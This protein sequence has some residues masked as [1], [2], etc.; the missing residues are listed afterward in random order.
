MVD[1]N[2]I[3]SV[4]PEVKSIDRLSYLKDDLFICALGFEP[5]CLSGVK[6]LDSNRYRTKKAIY[7]RYTA[8]DRENTKNLPDLKEYLNKVTNNNVEKYRFDR[9]HSNE[10]FVKFKEKI[11]SMMKND[12][13]LRVTIDVTSMTNTLITQILHF[14]LKKRIKFRIIYTEADIYHPTEEEF[15]EYIKKIEEGGQ[16]TQLLGQEIGTNI[17]LDGLEGEH[18][19]G[20]PPV[21]L[22]FVSFDYFRVQAAL[23][24]LK[25]PEFVIVLGE[26]PKK[27]RKWRL[28][29]QEELYRQLPVGI[30]N[31]RNIT[32]FNYKDVFE[33]LEKIYS[34]YEYSHNF[35]ISPL[36]SKLQTIGI[37]L[38]SLL[39]LDVQLIF[40]VPKEYVVE[41]YSKGAG[42][43]WTM[44]FDNS[45]EILD[46]F[47]D[48][49]R[50]E[51]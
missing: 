33:S 8:Q 32:T 9:F 42:D 19:L 27:E 18:H 31:F 5:R 34:N 50:I 23:D 25:P 37:T 21:L 45:G 51:R 46:L 29:A 4:L 7:F 10:S 3:L 48:Y 15:V 16:I 22:I 14:F 35:C 47:K 36:G 2:Q 26:P 44:E 41:K 17:I 43:I 38:F 12:E 20:C 28:K 6:K 1:L 24:F 13:N 30:K 11:K 40:P 39:H 49:K